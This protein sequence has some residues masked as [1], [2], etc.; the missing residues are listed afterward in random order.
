MIPFAPLAHPRRSEVSLPD[1]LC[2]ALPALL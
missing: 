1:G 2:I